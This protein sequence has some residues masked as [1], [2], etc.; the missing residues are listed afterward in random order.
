MD[1]VVGVFTDRTA[2]ER[3]VDLLLAYGV[4]RSRVTLLTPADAGR[5]G[6][7]VPTT[8]SEP[9]GIGR[10]LG[11]VVGSAAGAA[12]GIQAAA[13]SSLFVPGVGPVLTLGILGAIV[14]GMAGAAVGDALDSAL[15]EGL[16]KDEVFVYE[17]ALRKGR[18]VVVAL[19]GDA[20]AADAARRMLAEGGA[21]SLDAAREQWWLGLRDHEAA[22][23]VAEGHDFAREEAEFRRGFEAALSFGREVPRYDLA[24]P[25]LAERLVDIRDS[26]AFKR[27]YERGRQWILASRRD[28]AA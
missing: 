2:A 26:E 5:A 21:E 3:A 11:G 6:Q 27:G 9:P 15:R 20:K 7:A 8:E 14:L 1:T 25:Q 28:R 16:P 19:V 24:L 23:Y 22:A 18:T 12:T 4:P 10:A 17:D 13:L